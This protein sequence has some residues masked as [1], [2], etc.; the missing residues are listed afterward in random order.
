M[1]KRK[2]PGY[3]DI[4]SYR[5]LVHLYGAQQKV[6]DLAIK[7]I[8]LMGKKEEADCDVI[9]A[10]VKHSG[11]IAKLDKAVLERAAN[12]KR[13]AEAREKVLLK[14]I[15]DFEA[16]GAGIREAVEARNNE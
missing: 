5:E 3:T 6:A 11:D 7:M 14:A 9:W 15:Q 1:A 4:P 8:E 12:A 10:L 13:E 2:G 16:V